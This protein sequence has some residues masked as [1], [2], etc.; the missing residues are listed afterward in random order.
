DTEGL[1]AKMQCIAARANVVSEWVSDEI[2][3]RVAAAEFSINSKLP[4]YREFGELPYFVEKND[5]GYVL[6][7]QGGHSF[8]SF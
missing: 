4:H 8:L 3:D 7:Q 5:D 6:R 1:F 2:V